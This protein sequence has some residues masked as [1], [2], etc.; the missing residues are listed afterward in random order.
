MSIDGIL[1]RKLGITQVFRDDGTAVPVTVI[2][3]GPCTVV[4]VKTEEKDGYA[5]VQLGFGVRKR[6]NSPQKGHMKGLGQFLCLREF[7]VDDIS[8]WEIGKK[9][10]CEIFEEGDLVDVSGASKGR[11]FAGTIKRWGF[12]RGPKTHGSMNYRR[13]GAIGCSAYPGRGRQGADQK[14]KNRI[15]YIFAINIFLYIYFWPPCMSGSWRGVV[16]TTLMQFWVTWRGA[17]SIFLR[18]PETVPTLRNSELY[19]DLECSLK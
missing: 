4:Q 15:S 18:C 13:P 12:S 16:C 10:G 5:S 14:A 3:A 9:V 7:R 8:E 19:R 11:G 6:V 2:E 1:G 17:T